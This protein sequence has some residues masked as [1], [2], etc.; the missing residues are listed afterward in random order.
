MGSKTRERAWRRT[1]ERAIDRNDN[2]RYRWRKAGVGRCQHCRDTAPIIELRS[3]T[4]T[5]RT[6]DMHG[7]QA[8]AEIRATP[9]VCLYHAVVTEARATIEEA[10]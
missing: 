10:A 2:T 3:G 1:A 6:H 4:R 8:R 9:R 7:R 5:I